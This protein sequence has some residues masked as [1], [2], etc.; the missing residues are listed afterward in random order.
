M[1]RFEI[2]LAGISPDDVLRVE[3][4]SAGRVRILAMGTL[5]PFL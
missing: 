2:D 4:R 3:A 5:R 1:W